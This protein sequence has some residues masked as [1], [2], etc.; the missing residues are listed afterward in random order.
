[1][2]GSDTPVDPVGGQSSL[3]RRHPASGPWAVS[4]LPW[5][6]AGKSGAQQCPVSDPRD[7]GTAAVQRRWRRVTVE[8]SVRLK[9]RR[10]VR[11]WWEGKVGGGKGKASPE[12]SSQDTETLSTVE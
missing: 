11:E 4:P 8:V 7:T 3:R 2:V 10:T 5:S 12:G 9:N 6:N 1:M